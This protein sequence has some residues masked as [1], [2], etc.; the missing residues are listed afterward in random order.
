MLDLYNCND[1]SSLE[2]LPAEIVATTEQ[3]L[4]IKGVKSTVCNNSA[5]FVDLNQAQKKV[6]HSCINEHGVA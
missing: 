6:L 2:Q 5:R 4:D 1:G 3:I